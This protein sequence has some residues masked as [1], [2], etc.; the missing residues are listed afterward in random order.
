VYLFPFI[1]C[2]AQYIIIS[3][4]YPPPPSISS[5]NEVPPNADEVFWSDGSDVSIT[6]THYLT[7]N[8]N[9]NSLNIYDGGHVVTHWIKTGYPHELKIGKDGIHVNTS[10][11]VGYISGVGK[12][13]SSQQFLDVRLNSNSGLNDNLHIT[14][15]ISDSDMNKVGLRVT[16]P[17]Y[18]QR[19]AVVLGGGISNTFTGNVEVSGRG[20]ILALNKENGATAIQGNIFVNNG[21]EITLRR[22][23]QIADRASVKLRDSTFSFSDDRYDSKLIKRESFRELVIEGTSMLQFR[24]SEKSLDQ[25]FLYLNDLSVSDEGKLIVQGWKEGIHWLLVQK[26]SANLKDALEKIR[27]EGESWKQV[28]VRDY[29]WEYWEIGVGDDFSKLPEPATY[30]AVFGVV[31]LGLVIW[32]KRRRRVNDRSFPA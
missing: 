11:N 24:F 3:K 8:R 1:F 17:S 25:R 7:A 9:L 14:T 2:F 13:T 27:F 32:Q 10:S 31:G 21:A 4:T 22:G 15:V 6:S 5:Y 18:S 16:G 26:T 12:L 19:S 20:K 23:D 30:G 28:G 29:N